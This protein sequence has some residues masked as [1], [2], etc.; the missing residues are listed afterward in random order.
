MKQRKLVVDRVQ[1]EHRL[2]LSSSRK[3][4][5]Q[6]TGYYTVT[7]SQE[8]PVSNGYYVTL[9]GFWETLYQFEARAEK[10]VLRTI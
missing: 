9:A 10:E 6:E 2:F 7:A 3:S 8:M 5:S 1:V 4:Q